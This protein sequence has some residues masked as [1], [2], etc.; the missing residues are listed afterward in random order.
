MCDVILHEIHLHLA[1]TQ[2]NWIE[3]RS[4]AT[5]T[6][7]KALLAMLQFQHLLQQLCSIL[8]EPAD[9]GS[10]NASV[11]TARPTA[12]KAIAIFLVMP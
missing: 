6:V 3:L 4:F 2:S 10:E 1:P 5:A 9:A 7:R 11:E 12:A 8:Q